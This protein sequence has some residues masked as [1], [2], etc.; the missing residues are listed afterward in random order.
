MFLNDHSEYLNSGRRKL[1]ERTEE[2]QKVC[3]QKLIMVLE[4]YIKYFIL[5]L[6]PN[7][8]FPKTSTK[9]KVFHVRNAQKLAL[10]MENCFV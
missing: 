4:T 2:G 9:D 1:K 10:L 3:Q 7:Q 6:F 8:A 5:C